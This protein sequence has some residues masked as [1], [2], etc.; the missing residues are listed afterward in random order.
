MATEKKAAP[1]V[2]DGDEL[3]PVFLFKDNEKYK[4]DVFVAVNGATCQIQRG[5]QVMVKKKFADVLMQSQSQD[6][7]TADLISRKTSEFAAET[8]ARGL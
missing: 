4:H 6:M 3:V 2:K 1:V 7:A 8:K 5:K